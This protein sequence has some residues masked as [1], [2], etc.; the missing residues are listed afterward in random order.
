MQFV[1]PPDALAMCLGFAAFGSHVGVK[2]CEGSWLVARGSSEAHSGSLVDLYPVLPPKNSVDT[3]GRRL[4]PKA[5]FI[6][7]S[8]ELVLFLT[9]V[10]A[11][12]FGNK[13][14]AEPMVP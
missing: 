10:L 8:G 3:H 13:C 9:G 12:P 14:K 1:Q 11:L 7:C 5:M 6:M 2:W 4:L